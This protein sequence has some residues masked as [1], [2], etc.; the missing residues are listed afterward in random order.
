[1]ATYLE[2]HAQLAAGELEP[3]VHAS[4][5]MRHH[6][7]TVRVASSSPAASACDQ[8]EARDEDGP[9]VAAMSSLDPVHVEVA[10]ETRW[11]AWTRTAAEHGFG[12]AVAVPARVGDRTAVALNLYLERGRA[13]GEPDMQVA[14]QHAEMVADSVRSRLTASSTRRVEA[15]DGPGGALLVDQA[16]GVL[17]QANGVDA[18]VARA[19]LELVA[20]REHVPVA[21]IAVTILAAVTDAR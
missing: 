17:M 13:W 16:I 9:C 14:R 11:P 8:A 5:T 4:I 20:A 6:G 19:L 1:M 3:G 12:G 15:T 18:H 7:A 21:D 2:R 10:G